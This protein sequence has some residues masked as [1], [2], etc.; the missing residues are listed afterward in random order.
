MTLTRLHDTGFEFQST[1]EVD[2]YVPYGS[3]MGIISTTAGTMRT[4]LAS[5]SISSGSYQK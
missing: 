2:S 3:S 5:F 1:T 4:G